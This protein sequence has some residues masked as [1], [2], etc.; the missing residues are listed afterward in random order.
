MN[1]NVG[2]VVS[3][4][5]TIFKI[6][7]SLLPVSF[8]WFSFANPK[9]CQK[10]LHADTVLYNLNR[11]PLS[12]WRLYIEHVEFRF[13]LPRFL[14]VVD[15][16]GRILSRSDH[17]ASLLLGLA[18]IQYLYDTFQHVGG[19]LLNNVSTLINDYRL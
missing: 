2:L 7:Q 14:K 6:L 15:D 13:D 17:L 18:Y 5:V 4:V 10:E 11:K 16:D 8:S 9:S 19:V 3:H 12:P 1:N